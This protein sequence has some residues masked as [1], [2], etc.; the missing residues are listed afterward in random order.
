MH[1]SQRKT[2]E[3]IAVQAYYRE[4]SALQAVDNWEGAAQAYFEG[5]RMD[6]QNAAMAQAF[7]KAVVKAREAH[8]AAHRHA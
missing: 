8:A 5:F 4:G 2:D 6:P 3:H 1:I 7:Q